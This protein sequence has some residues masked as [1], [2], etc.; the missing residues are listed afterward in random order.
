MSKSSFCTSR[1]R[2]STVPG[3][4]R[5]KPSLRLDKVDNA[6]DMPA[7]NGF[8]SKKSILGLEGEIPAE[9]QLISPP[10][11]SDAVGRWKSINL[12][13]SGRSDGDCNGDCNGDGDGVLNY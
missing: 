10:R 6:S 1:D 2:C 8:W 5:P 13:W 7:T 4:V 3:L 9:N 12:S 11:V